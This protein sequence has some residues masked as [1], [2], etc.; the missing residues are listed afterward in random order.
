MLYNLHCVEADGEG[1]CDSRLTLEKAMERK[2]A[3]VVQFIEG[4]EE[5]KTPSLAW[6]W[7]TDGF[8]P[9][10]WSLPLAERHPEFLKFLDRPAA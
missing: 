5:G 1:W 2:D 6:N 3:P 9:F 8:E 4:F 7:S 10:D